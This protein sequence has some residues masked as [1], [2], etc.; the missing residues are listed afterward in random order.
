MRLYLAERARRQLDNYIER[1]G[2]E[3]DARSPPRHLEAVAMVCTLLLDRI[4][5]LGGRTTETVAYTSQLAQL[6]RRGVELW[7]PRPGA[8]RAPCLRLVK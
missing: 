2:L 7:T 8:A 5:E 6:T 1:F 3:I 4:E